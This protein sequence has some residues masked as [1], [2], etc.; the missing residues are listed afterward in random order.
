MTPVPRDHLTSMNDTD[1]TR[2]SI[3]VPEI[4]ALAEA[5]DMPH[6]DPTRV[7]RA[8]LERLTHLNLVRPLTLEQWLEMGK[9]FINADRA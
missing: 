8:A 6:T 3:G 5:L 2:T 4:R 9:R 1:Y 7:A